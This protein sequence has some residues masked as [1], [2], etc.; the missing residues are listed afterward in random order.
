MDLC[1]CVWGVSIH[2]SPFCVSCQFWKLNKITQS[3]GVRVSEWAKTEIISFC[4]RNSVPLGTP[5][6]MSSILLERAGL[7]GAGKIHIHIQTQSHSRISEE[8]L[9]NPYRSFLGSVQKQKK[10]F[11]ILALCPAGWYN[12][13]WNAPHWERGRSTSASQFIISG[14][15]RTGAMPAQNESRNLINLWRNYWAF[16]SNT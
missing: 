2:Q 10:F 7:A 3:V 5:G 15:E 13:F 8:G 9:L 14:F 12:R 4:L 6:K 16:I 1:V 11:H